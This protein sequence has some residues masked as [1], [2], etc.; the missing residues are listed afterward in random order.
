MKPQ[1]MTAVQGEKVIDINGTPFVVPKECI[2]DDSQLVKCEFYMLSDDLE[3]LKQMFLDEYGDWN[4]SKNKIL[5]DHP[6]TNKTPLSY[7][8]VIDCENMMEL[9]Q[10]LYHYLKPFKKEDK[11]N[12]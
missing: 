10:R 12:E 3:F 1:I 7:F 2:S 6:D 11:T 4:I 5:E 8:R 9:F